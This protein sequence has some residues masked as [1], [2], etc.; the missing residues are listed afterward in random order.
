MKLR[1]INSTRESVVA[2]CALLAGDSALRRKG[3]LAQDSFVPG[4]GLWLAPCEAVHTFGMK[5]PIDILFLDKRRRVRKVRHAVPRSRI[6]VDLFAHSVLE[7]PAGTIKRTAT[8]VGD[9]LQFEK[10]P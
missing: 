7:L 10:E 8:G 9:Q 3:L 4:T 2:E 5:F 1:I 6:A